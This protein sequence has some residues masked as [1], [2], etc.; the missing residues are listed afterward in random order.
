M[1]K[2]LT[3]II[4]SLLMGCINF[5][6]K[7]DHSFTVNLHKYRPMEC[8]CNLYIEGYLVFGMGALGSD[9]YSVY[10]TDSSQFRIYIGNYDENDEKLVY[11]CKGDSVYVEKRT[12]K[13]YA[14]DDWD[15]FKILENKGYSV[16]DLKKRHV[17]E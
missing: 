8:M 13:G 4:V 16:G 3:L 1:K 14:R 6:S 17:F 15:T 11:I 10:L 9:L 7:K 2:L 12:N 5:R